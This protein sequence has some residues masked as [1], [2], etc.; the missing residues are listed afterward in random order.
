M[1]IAYRIYKMGGKAMVDEGDHP[2]DMLFKEE[3][4]ILMKMKTT[5]RLR[6]EKLDKDLKIKIA[7]IDELKQSKN[8][9]LHNR[10]GGVDNGR[11]EVL[12]K[13]KNAL[14]YSREARKLMDDIRKIASKRIATETTE[15]TEGKYSVLSV[16][17][18]GGKKNILYLQK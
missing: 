7:C 6:N 13:I 11:K 12:R 8:I 10:K 5:F 1:L 4:E 15:H 9:M 3:E 17:V 2:D 14:S 18:L 16:Y